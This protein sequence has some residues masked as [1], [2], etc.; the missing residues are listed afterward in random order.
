MEF[1]IILSFVFSLIALIRSFVTSGQKNK[2]LKNTRIVS[3]QQSGEKIYSVTYD[4]GPGSKTF[5]RMVSIK[6]AY[7]SESN[8]ASDGL[9]KY[10]F[11]DT[12]SRVDKN[13]KLAIRNVMSGLSYKAGRYLELIDKA[14]E[15]IT[16]GDKIEALEI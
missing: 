11:M 6:S 4:K 3:I 5:L 12:F 1:L 16:L 7:H 8:I 10:Y 2:N 14:N 9:A 15:K 13:T